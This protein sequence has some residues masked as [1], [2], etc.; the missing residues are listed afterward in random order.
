MDKHKKLE[1]IVGPKQQKVRPR[2]TNKFD[3][4]FSDKKTTD[5]TN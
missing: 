3:N 1:Y 4:Q 2:H 5:S